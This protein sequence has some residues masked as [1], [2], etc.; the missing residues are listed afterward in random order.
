M[1]LSGVLV[2]LIGISDGPPHACSSADQFDDT[3]RRCGADR[4]LSDAAAVF[5]LCVTSVLCL[6][7]KDATEAPT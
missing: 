7:V 5:A 1:R 6:I 4:L 3:A 2:A